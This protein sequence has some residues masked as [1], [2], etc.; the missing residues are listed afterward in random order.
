[1]GLNSNTSA[2]QRLRDTAFHRIG[3]VFPHIFNKSGFLGKSFLEDN[4]L[5][6]DKPL[7]PANLYLEE[8]AYHLQLALPG[9]KKEEIAISI[10]DGIL[11][12]VAESQSSQNSQE[13]NYKLQ[14]FA[15]HRVERSFQLSEDVQVEKIEAQFE[16]GLL[17]LTLPQAKPVTSNPTK[18]IQIQ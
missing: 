12:I 11:H 15:T 16:N 1:M 13:N 2:L 3:D 18:N 4:F 8:E 14:E 6:P 17:K 7:A 10:K 5:A 9:F